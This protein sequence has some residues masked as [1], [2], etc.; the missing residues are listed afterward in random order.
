[1]HTETTHPRA[2]MDR[3]PTTSLLILILIVSF[4]FLGGCAAAPAASDVPIRTS[5]DD[6]N[7]VTIHIP[8]YLLPEGVDADDVRAEYER[9][10]YTDI[11]VA[12]DGSLRIRLTRNQHKALVDVMNNHTGK[13]LSSHLDSAATTGVRAIEHDDAFRIITIRVDESV[14]PPDR[15]HVTSWSVGITAATWQ[16]YAGHEVDVNVRLVD[17]EGTLLEVVSI[18]EDVLTE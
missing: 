6:E 18:P 10:G 1:M 11:T 17:S 3:L 12:E 2:R 4:L 9:Q 7:A 8:G 14:F 13:E 5:V 16:A 15:A